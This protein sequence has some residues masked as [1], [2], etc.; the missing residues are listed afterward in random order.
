LLFDD[1]TIKEVLENESNK[2]SRED[3]FN[4]LDI[5]VKNSKDEIII[6][7]IQYGRELDYMQ[8]MLYGSAKAIAEYITPTSLE[9]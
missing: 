7:E 8:R 9:Q 3:K 1:I 6:I 4:R 2:N 5:K